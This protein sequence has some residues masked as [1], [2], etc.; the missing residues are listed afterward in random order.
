MERYSIAERQTIKDRLA[1]EEHFERDRELFAQIFPHHPL[2]TELARVNRV[3]K[4][5]LC[6]RMIYQLLQ[7]VDESAILEWRET[8]ARVA[9]KHKRHTRY[10]RDDSRTITGPYTGRQPEEDRETTGTA[11]VKKA[12]KA[13][14]FPRINWTDNTNPDIQ[15][16]I[17]LYDERVNTW[18]QMVALRADID[19]CP[20]KALAIA[21]LDDRNRMAQHELEVYQDTHIFPCKHPIAVQF[22]EERATMNKFRELKRTDPDKFMK[23][24]ANIRHNSTR[25]RASL[26]K[27]DLSDDER[28]RQEKN[29]ERSERLAELM[30]R[31][32]QE[33]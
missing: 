5:A 14:E 9:G 15:L 33:G 16:C 12:G 10:I 4:A 28:R 21:E 25:I 30:Q 8:G 11:P 18:H 7:K 26:K 13:D 3:N 27:K 22:L 2:M 17:L 31:V 23:Q 24:A 6:R 19:N 1:S 20:E 29:L 32:L